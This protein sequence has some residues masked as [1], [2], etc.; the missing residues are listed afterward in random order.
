MFEIKRRVDYICQAGGLIFD[1]LVPGVEVKITSGPFA[2]YDGIFD[3]RLSG[4]ER[5][6]VLLTLIAKKQYRREQPRPILVDI[7]VNSI[8]RV[9]LK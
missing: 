4:T 7:N 1:G 3:S 2:G 6:R 8:A 5:V 9:K